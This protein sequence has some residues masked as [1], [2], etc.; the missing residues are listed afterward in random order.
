MDGENKETFV[1]TFKNWFQ[2]LGQVSVDRLAKRYSKKMDQVILETERQKSC[3]YVGGQFLFECT[4]EKVFTMSTALYF[5]DEEKNWIQVQSKSE[6]INMD[7]LT[8]ESARELI[9]K[10]KIPFEVD[11]PARH[12]SV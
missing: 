8:P 7:Q 2:E 3:H 4:D 6:P 12:V 10:K 5:Q 9:E 1:N 11:A